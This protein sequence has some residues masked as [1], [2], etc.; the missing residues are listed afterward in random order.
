MS[1]NRSISNSDDVIDSR[2][3]IARID[4]LQADRDT[5]VAAEVEAQEEYDDIVPS[6]RDESHAEAL[7]KAKAELKEWDEGDDG[8][9]LKTLLAPAQRSPRRAMC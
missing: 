2:D 6:E 3:V 7:E 4:E 1:R 9:E 8:A 5:F